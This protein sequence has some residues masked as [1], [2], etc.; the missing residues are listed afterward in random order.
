MAISVGLAL[1]WV[2]LACSR[3]EM[4]TPSPTGD[5]SLGT[6]VTE[7]VEI[8]PAESSENQDLMPERAVNGSS[9]A[10]G[11]VTHNVVAPL[12]L[13]PLTASN[14][15]DFL[16]GE[17]YSG[18]VSI[19]YGPEYA[20]E[21]DLASGWSVTDDGLLYTFTLRDGL[22]FSNGVPL[23]AEGVK[24][25]WARALSPD[26]ATDRARVVLGVILGAQQMLGGASESLAGITVIDDATLSVELKRQTAH[27]LHALA[28]PVASVLNRENFEGWGTVN[29]VRHQ[30]DRTF[31]GPDDVVFD[32]LPAGTGPFMIV[33]HDHSYDVMLEPNPNYW[34][35]APAG[36]AGVTYSNPYQGSSPWLPAVMPE[37]R[38]FDSME[39]PEEWARSI[40]D[41]D[42]I[43]SLGDSVGIFEP[44]EVRRAP[45]VTWLA[46]NPA[47]EPFDDLEF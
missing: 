2:G 40:T 45:Q 35:G 24:W 36:V 13:D 16:L 28:D 41:G 21:P 32:E 1:V 11:R 44:L 30:H 34:R 42:P 20:P 18:L 43:I 10:A 38:D 5:P 29:W 9:Q 22:R 39:A 37:L 26:Y 14:W 4:A 8:E 3:G 27:F 23:T 7:G 19:G 25:S 31:G 12:F 33:A 47:V 6:P 17:I 46:L 15:N